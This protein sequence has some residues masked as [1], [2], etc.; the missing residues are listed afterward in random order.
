MTVLGAFRAAYRR[1]GLPALKAS[2]LGCTSLDLSVVLGADTHAVLTTSTA[3]GRGIAAEI[4]T[5]VDLAAWSGVRLLDSC[6]QPIRDETISI[7]RLKGWGLHLA[8]RSRG[9]PPC[10][11]WPGGLC[12]GNEVSRWWWALADRAGAAGDGAVAGGTA[13]RRGRG[14]GG[15]GGPAAGGGG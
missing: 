4:T 10:S 1:H 14:A 12:R 5:G 13:V 11:V 15:G 9:A 3:G 7:Q 8:A 6:L 2:E